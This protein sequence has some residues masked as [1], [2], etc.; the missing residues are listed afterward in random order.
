[1][2]AA[3]PKATA[4]KWTD[5]R[6]TFEELAAELPESN[7]PA[8][9]WDGELVMR[10]APPFFHQ[11]P[12]GRYYRA[13]DAWGSRHRLGKT[14]IAPLDMVLTTR[15]STQATGGSVGGSA[16]KLVIAR[17]NAAPGKTRRET[18][19]RSFMAVGLKVIADSESQGHSPRET[20]RFETHGALTRRK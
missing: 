19:L 14:A 7:L 4:E 18:E 8:E 13:L 6:W 20:P 12:V 11:E 9:L 17:N 10:H 1:M 16:R 2:I 5:R 3:K 15:R